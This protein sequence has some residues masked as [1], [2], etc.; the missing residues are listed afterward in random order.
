MSDRYDDS[1]DSRRYERDDRSGWRCGEDEI[2]SSLSA[3]K[4]MIVCHMAGRALYSAR[5]RPAP[6]SAAAACHSA[7]RGSLTADSEMDDFFFF[8][9]FDMAAVTLN[10]YPNPPASTLNHGRTTTPLHRPSGPRPR[11]V[12]VLPAAASAFYGV[13]TRRDVRR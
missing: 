2:S 10:T 9:F 13:L 8:F 11:A 4:R 3:A 7:T 6:S 1:R 5:R 12:H